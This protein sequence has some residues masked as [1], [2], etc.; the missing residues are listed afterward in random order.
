MDINEAGEIP[1]LD[2]FFTLPPNK[3]QK[4]T[5]PQVIVRFIPDKLPE[6]PSRTQLIK[7]CHMKLREIIHFR[8]EEPDLEDISLFLL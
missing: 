2:D 4:P 1:S 3:V 8:V 5:V 6:Y 7:E